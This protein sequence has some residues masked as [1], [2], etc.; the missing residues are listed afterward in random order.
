MKQAQTL[1]LDIRI[2]NQVSNGLV[3][4]LVLSCLVAGVAW[5]LRHP[6]FSI[7]AITVD[8]DVTHNNAVTLRA[9]VMPHLTGN[10]FTLNLGQAREVFETVPWV[11]QAVVHRQYPNRLRVTLQEHQPI[12]LWGDTQLNLMVNRQSEV[13]EADADD[14]E[15]QSLPRFLGPDGQAAQVV[16]MYQFL[17]PIYEA[18]S[19]S[20]DTLELTPRGS[21]RV[22]TRA[23]ATMELGRGS[24]QEIGNRL[25]VFWRSLSQITARYGRTPASLLA[26]DL[27]HADGYAVR[28]KGVSTVESDGKKR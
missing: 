21:W 18:M 3:M 25:Q 16:R 27:R 8:G 19:M 15:V 5:L 20:V 23:G 26:A 24:A 22:E 13:F 12:A 14:A 17:Q 10:F 28:L 9:N 1:P 2:M 6:L 7:R 4:L 11:R